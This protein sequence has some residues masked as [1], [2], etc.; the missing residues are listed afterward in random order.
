MVKG[1]KNSRALSTSEQVIM[2]VDSV[3]VA[4]LPSEKQGKV[5]L[6]LVQVTENNDAGEPSGIG[7]VLAIVP[8]QQLA[9]FAGST[10]LAAH[11]AHARTANQTGT[12]QSHQIGQA[13]PPTRIRVIEPRDAICPP[14]HAVLEITVGSE[15]VLQFHAPT[16]VWRSVLATL[17]EAG[18]EDSSAH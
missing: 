7:G 11:L 16:D 10:L 3:G 15:A 8:D 6:E 2:R 4:P 9:Q 14:G 17:G 5:A 18:T 1:G 13:L 12:G